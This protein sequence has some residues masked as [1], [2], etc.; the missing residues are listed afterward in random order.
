MLQKEDIK[1]HRFSYVHHL[2]TVDEESQL[3]LEE[4]HITKS[5]ARDLRYFSRLA[6]IVTIAVLGFSLP[7]YGDS[8]SLISDQPVN[9]PLSAQMA[10][11]PAGFPPAWRSRAVALNPVVASSDALVPGDVITLNLFA[12]TVLTAQVERVSKN[13]NGTVTIRGRFEN[14]PLGYVIITTTN[15]NSLVSIQIPETDKRYRIQMDTLTGTHYLLEENTDQLKELEDAPSP[16]PPQNATE[17]EI[18]SGN[19]ANGPLDPV[20]FD[21]M[22]VYTPAARVWA[23]GLSGI[24]NVIAQAVA[25]GQIAL[26]NSNTVLTLTLVYSGEISYTESGDSGTDLDRLTNTSDGYMDEVHTLR[27][28][29]YADVVGLFTQ[30]E[31]T[32]GKG[33]LLNSTSGSPAYAFSISRVQ[34]AATGYTYIHEMGHNMGCHHR[35]DQATQPGPGLFSYSAGWRWTGNNSGKYC[36]VMSYEDDGYSRVA[37]FSNPS[38]LYQGVATGNA[39][40]GDNARTIREI[41]NVI[42]AYRVFAGYTLT[43]NSSGASSVS[44]SSSTGHSGTTN[45]TKAVSSGTSVTLTAPLYVGSCASRKRF[46]GWT[47]SVTSSSQSITF[48]MDGVKTVTA[49]YVADPEISP[50]APTGASA[51][52]TL[53]DRIQMGWG[54]VSGATTYEICRN[55][56]NNSGSASYLGDDSS[57]PYDDYG[58]TAGVTYYYWVK[59][60]NACGTSGFSSPD[61]GYRSTV[62]VITQHPQDTTVYVGQDANFSVVAAGLAPLHYQWKKNSGNVGA[63][64]SILTLSYVQLSDN[65]AQIT[66]DV[67]NACGTTTSSTAILAVSAE[68]VATPSFLP[69][70]G[71]YSSPVDVTISC[72]T[73]GTTIHYTTNGI[74]PTESDLVY[75]SPIN[76]SLTT[77]LKAKAWKSG[78]NPSNTATTT[79]SIYAGG[80]IMAWGVNSSGQCNVP[81]PNT[82]FTAIAAGFYHSLGLKADGSIVAWGGNYAGQCNVPSP[83]TGFVAIAA[84]VYH[85]LGLKADG[86]I[87]A[88]G[89]NYDGQCNVP[90]PNTGFTAIAA[91]SCHSLGLKA[92]SSIV[93]W[94]DNY[95]GQCTVP[96]PNTGFTAIAGPSGEHSLGLKQNGSIVAWGYNWYGQCTVPSPN[97]GFTAIAGGVY[98]S[99][100]LK[101]NGSIVAW[102]NN[103]VGQCAVPSPNTGF[104]AIAAGEFHSLGLKQNGSIVAWGYN[105]YGQC[106]VPSPNTGFIAITASG[107]HS[108]GLKNR[109]DFNGDKIVNFNDFA[110]LAYYW[111]DALCTAPDWCEGCDYDHSGKVDIED[112]KTFEENWL[113]QE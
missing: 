61:S 27:N 9:A 39:A 45:Y 32:G 71:A 93:A 101:Q 107:Y 86:S 66:C 21:V 111:V 98:H 79:Y 74:D 106:T 29:Y 1:M 47:G 57:S 38:I 6:F 69:V 15:N 33:W 23:G 55:T 4:A 65:G 24:N 18:L 49:N 90:S 14:Y 109:S 78:W 31:D 89:G 3:V 100:G 67:S 95:F 25:K 80:E 97:T 17:M 113:W 103:S 88:W 19:I 112:L 96:F 83:N 105:W 91:G 68:T 102:G 5:T 44:I 36:S 94:G 77:T 50:G 108:L 16:I 58:A 53:C 52:D 110:F 63:D 51:T 43:V 13:I 87:V 73:S 12:D 82:A 64:N 75:T 28:L 42:A 76:I 8:Y 35:K 72:G 20:N 60:K 11:L 59:A 56:T 104:T 85:S 7:G 81:L 10:G 84:G 62:P 34:Q 48:P 40:D 99:L 30:I 26:N 2:N 37:Y 46:D 54:S 22:I 41:K 92:D 70:R